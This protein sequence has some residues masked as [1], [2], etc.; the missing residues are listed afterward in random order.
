MP[1]VTPNSTVYL[2]G[3][4][5][6]DMNNSIWWHHWAY[7]DDPRNS[8]MWHT[9]FSFFKAHSVAN[10]YWYC[11]YIAPD[12]GYVDVGKQF[13]VPDE[14]KHD[15]TLGSSALQA[16][17]DDPNHPYQAYL[18][19]IDYMIIANDNLDGSASSTIDVQYCFVDLIENIN[20]STV[21]IHFTV[22][23]L[24]TYQKY[25]HFGKC[26]VDRDMQWQEWKESTM[27]KIETKNYNRIADSVSPDQNSFVFSEMTGSSE[28]YTE[29]EFGTYNYRLTM[30]DIMLS[31]DDIQGRDDAPYI[32]ELKP[33]K[34]TTFSHYYQL[35]PDGSTADNAESCPIGLGVYHLS[36]N[37]ETDPALIA[38]G[39]FDAMEHLLY[40]WCVPYKFF[41]DFIPPSQ[42]EFIQDIGASIREEY[43]G[44][45]EYKIRM[46]HLI[47][48]DKYYTESEPQTKDDTYKP[49][50]AK[51]YS[52][53]YCYFSVS[54]NKGGSA[55][56]IPQLLDIDDDNWFNM[57]FRMQLC[58]APNTLSNWYCTN[59]LEIQ[60]TYNNPFQTLW[61]MPT[62]A[63]TPN[64]S[65]YN[66]SLVQEQSAINLQSK[67]IEVSGTGS[68][69]EMTNKLAG[70]IG[71]ALGVAIGGAVGTAVATPA[72]GVAGAVAGA[73]LGSAAGKAMGTAIT[74]A[75]QGMTQPAAQQAQSLRGAAY[76]QMANEAELHEKASQLQTYG[77]PKAAGGSA[78]GFNLFSAMKPK[79]TTYFVHLN[80]DNMRQ[81]DTYFSIFGYRQNKFKMPNINTRSRWCYVRLQTV[82]YLPIGANNYDAPG[83][84]SWV[85]AQITKRLNSGV[86]FWNLRHKLSGG[87]MAI[88]SL[89]WQDIPDDAIKC[90]FVK[91]YGSGLRSPEMIQNISYVGDFASEYNEYK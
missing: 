31:A 53:P 62:Y 41:T 8:S 19:A 50:N 66:N 81:L 13:L 40:T 39:S 65:G 4:T 26:M 69:A 12:A 79:Y 76:A 56:V 78:S 52:A 32:P 20:H 55:E 21:R 68:F 15:T 87:S 11:T 61:Q 49:L 83:L 58:A 75:L 25:F 64:G 24:M 82:T 44:N 72:G 28:A 71:A 3:G 89:D 46:P 80:K 51:C 67:M 45:K 91:N 48:D 30:S 35:Q 47:Q 73:S 16:D 57:K 70:G 5:G 33:S 63:M 10:G 84:P 18:T 14:L 60:P 37:D 88:V 27:N 29:T 38:L 34:K 17:L 7:S 2:L 22:D 77:L 36:T 6:M 59:T 1:H 90:N 86:T 85:Q 9:V 23:A 74:G 54:D 42:A 43:R